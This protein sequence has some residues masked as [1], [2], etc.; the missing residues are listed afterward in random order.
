[1]ED[2]QNNSALHA[3][4]SKLCCPTAARP[5][6]G[7][8][9]WDTPPD[10]FGASHTVELEWTPKLMTAKRLT[11][12]PD[13]VEPLVSWAL[14]LDRGENRWRLSQSSGDL[15]TPL[16]GHDAPGLGEC[17]KR[18]GAQ[19]QALCQQPACSWRPVRSPRP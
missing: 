13:Q 14:S 18:A 15:F 4:L 10:M 5:D 3:H 7:T 6:N 17:V 9:R 11:V 2:N 8:A 1:M 19:I 16:P 12:L